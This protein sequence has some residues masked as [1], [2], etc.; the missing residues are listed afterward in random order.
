MYRN[1]ENGKTTVSGM[2]NERGTVVGRA[3]PGDRVY[4]TFTSTPAD[5]EVNGIFRRKK[6]LH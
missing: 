2:E 4:L 3:N 6:K 5:L 1:A